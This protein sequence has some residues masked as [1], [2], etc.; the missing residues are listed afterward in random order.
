MPRPIQVISLLPRGRVSY[1]AAFLLQK[2]AEARVKEGGK[3][4][5]FLLEH[6]EVITVGRNADIGELLVS[7]EA[8]LREGVG[9]RET[10]RGGKLT[11]HGPGQLVAYP[12]LDLSP[13]RRDVRRYV[14]DLEDVLIATAADFGVTAARSDAPDRWASVWAGEEKLAAIGVPL[15]RW[16]T[17][18]GG[19]LNVSSHLA[20]LSLIISCRNADAC[21]TSLPRL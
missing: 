15:S 12:I 8:L 10:D 5:L 3:E 2:E 4:A 20:R 16:V 7:E 13:D 21:G 9:L 6:E 17:T 18:H 19:A 1:D 14:H 11:Y